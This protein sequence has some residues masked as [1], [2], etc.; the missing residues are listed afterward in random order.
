[1]SFTTAKSVAPFRPAAHTS[2][3]IAKTPRVLKQTLQGPLKVDIA[4]LSAP[5]TRA[6]PAEH[7]SQS[8]EENVRPVSPPADMDTDAAPEP[9]SPPPTSPAALSAK[10][11]RAYEHERQ[12]TKRAGERAAH[13]AKKAAGYLS[14]VGG[15]RTL[16][17][18]GSEKDK[19]KDGRRRLRTKRAVEVEVDTGI[20]AV[21]RAASPVRAALL[22]E[23]LGG[24]VD[25]GAGVI[26][27][28]NA[29]AARSVGGVGLGLE[30]D[31]GSLLAAAGQQRKGR[32]AV[33][34]G[35]ELVPAVRG[36]IALDDMPGQ[37]AE[38]EEGWEHVER[39]EAGRV[40][41]SYAQVLLR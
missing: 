25:S 35:F 14:S 38:V 27:Q 2:N 31:L 37:M 13:R 34:D 32:G 22:V 33:R 41:V 16:D 3:T 26:A 23:G 18:A 4:P 10:D 30:V 7:Q 36:V 6:P 29:R 17:T 40:S 15:K 12:R 19:D 5:A 39:E 28:A 24:A 21:D 9:L 11:A 1:M 8:D 20:D